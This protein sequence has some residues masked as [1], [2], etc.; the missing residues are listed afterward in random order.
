[1]G[2]LLVDEGSAPFGLGRVD[3]LVA[4][5][6]DA[7]QVAIDDRVH[8]ASAVRQPRREPG[9]VLTSAC[10]PLAPVEIDKA[11][12]LLLSAGLLVASCSL[13]E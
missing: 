11:Q 8:G 13:L 4:A 3:D 2:G 9:L 12:P 5:G 6:A 10:F 7:Q 1:M